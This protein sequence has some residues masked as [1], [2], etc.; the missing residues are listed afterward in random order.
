MKKEGRLDASFLF[1]NMFFSTDSLPPMFVRFLL[2][3]RVLASQKATTI[4]CREE[5]DY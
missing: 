3:L 4:P 2:R 1:V 5:K